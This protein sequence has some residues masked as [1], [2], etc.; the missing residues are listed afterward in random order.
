MLAQ[1][2]EVPRRA[3]HPADDE[4]TA[5]VAA[6]GAKT[7]ENREQG[8]LLR[9]KRD[10]AHGQEELGQQ[11]ADLPPAG[12]EQHAEEDQGAE[13]MRLGQLGEDLDACSIAG[14]A[15]EPEGAQARRPDDQRGDQEPRIVPERPE[16]ALPRRGRA[17]N[18][19]TRKEPP[20]TARS[21]AIRE[22]RRAVAYSANIGRD[23][24]G[25]HRFHGQAAAPDRRCAHRA[26]DPPVTSTTSRSR[27]SIAGRIP[28][29]SQC[30][31]A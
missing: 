18:R 20:T 26:P 1:Q 22:R 4:S 27:A 12:D 14:R 5:E 8:E 29:R 24:R 15:V 17:G 10:E 7:A 21:I 2:L 25:D 6:A 31:R 11:A 16:L 3:V 23:P 9:G 28:A 19:P 30:A 13:G